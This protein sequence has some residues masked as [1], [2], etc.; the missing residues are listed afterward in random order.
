MEINPNIKETIALPRFARGEEILPPVPYLQLL[1]GPQAGHIWILEQDRLRLGRDEKCDIVLDLAGVSRVHASLE[2]VQNDYEILDEESTNGTFVNGHSAI[3]LGLR[4]SDLIDLGPCCSL[5]FGRQRR[6]DIELVQ[7]LFEG[8]KLDGL[9]RVM[10][11]ATFF[12]SLEQEIAFSAR[13]EVPFCLLMFDI[14]HFK[15]VNDTY[16]H[17]AGDEVLRQVANQARGLLRLEDTLGRYG[18]EEFAILL[19]GTD[20]Q[21]A[22]HVAERI[23]VKV[24]K[25]SVPLSEGIQIAVTVSLGLSQWRPDLTGD[26]LLAQADQA[27]YHSKENGRNR[28]TVFPP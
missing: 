8:A 25:L 14:D 7:R 6:S 18:G 22:L 5:K 24:A 2:R 21:G 20:E 17:P 16:G 26:E 28:S 4:D 1:S 27:L 23:R 13:H 10:N 19:R 15:S 9:T 12:E 11:R 3:R